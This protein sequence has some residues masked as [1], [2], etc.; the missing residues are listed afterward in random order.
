MLSFFFPLFFRNFISMKNVL[1]FILAI[2]TTYS[3]SQS[4]FAPVGTSWTYNWMAHNGGYNGP[5]SLYYSGDTMISGTSYKK[6]K[7]AWNYNIMGPQGP[8]IG[9]S[10][11]EYILERNDSIM[12]V[13]P[14]SGPNQL[15]YAFNHSA[16]D[17]IYFNQT[18][19]YKLAFDSM[20]V[21]NTFCSSNRRILYYTKIENSCT[22]P[23]TIVESLG[24]IDDY[25]FSQGI[26]NCE[27]GPGKYTFNCVN[28]GSCM[29]SVAS[30]S[31]VPYSVNELA[32]NLEFTL[33]QYNDHISVFFNDQS[34]SL[35][36]LYDLHGK[37][38][39]SSSSDNPSETIISTRDLFGAIYILRINSGQKEH[40][41]K[42]IIN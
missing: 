29:Y 30:C 36:E 34:H 31:P 38:I 28:T 40:R 27:L 33:L 42:I 41:R 17:T 35:A 25:L 2:T 12:R 19:P 1:F 9:S 32:E 39:R 22:E 4:V 13:Y 5:K 23:V 7:S 15:L 6:I 10:C 37:K 3:F 14:G 24:P 18:T 21:K 16:G 8:Q 26:S 20:K 11:C